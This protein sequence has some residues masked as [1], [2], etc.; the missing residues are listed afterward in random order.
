M[1]SRSL[2][3]A[4][5][6]LAMVWP[7][8]PSGDEAAASGPDGSR[9]ASVRVFQRGVFTAPGE[10]P[11]SI[12]VALARLRP[13]FVT[14]PLRYRAR[15]RVTE[16]EM[17]AWNTIREAVRARRPRAQFAVALN[18]LHYT[19]ARRLETTM[20]RIR[21]RI[22]PD[23]WVFD[24]YS[25]AAARRKRVLRAAVASAHRHGETIGGVAFGIAR[26]PRIPGG[27][28]FV[29][30]Q[31][32][33]F[34][35]D[36][37]AV[38]ALAR[39]FPVHMQLGNDPGHPD[40]DGC[41]FIRELSTRERARYIERRARQQAKYAFRFSYPVFFPA[42]VDHRGEADG[43]GGL[44]TYNATEDAGMMRTIRRLMGRYD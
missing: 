18:A 9:I 29:V 22:A 33:R 36:L 19:R 8:A 13:T 17:N 10:T 20:A 4:A 12:G 24:F 37:D 35:I 34:R 1:F 11:E 26:Q 15:D 5:V 28:D 6:L 38:A 43:R 27:T 30:V 16:R 41:R 3:L 7:G 32:T 21:R 23:A 39:R 42:C 25:R 31:P 40:S 44:V 14:A 2:A